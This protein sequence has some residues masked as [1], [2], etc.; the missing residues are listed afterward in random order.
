MDYYADILDSVVNSLKEFNVTQQ[1]IDDFANGDMFDFMQ[2]YDIWEQFGGDHYENFF[3]YVQEEAYND[4]VM[5]KSDVLEFLKYIANKLTYDEFLERVDYY[6]KEI[7]FDAM[8]FDELYRLA[9]TDTSTN[10]ELGLLFL[11][12]LIYGGHVFFEPRIYDDR[13]LNDV[14]RRLD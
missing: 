10:H 8:S 4:V 7:G 11:E 2:D 14:Y 5:S 1:D 3:N 12:D 13:F 6:G 9:N